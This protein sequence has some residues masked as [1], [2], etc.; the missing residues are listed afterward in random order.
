MDQFSLTNN[1]IGYRI[2]VAK[3]SIISNNIFL[4]GDPVGGGFRMLYS[5]DNCVVRNNI[6]YKILWDFPGLVSNQLQNNLFANQPDMT[7]NFPSANF[8]NVNT[9]NLFVSYDNSGF[10]YNH[11]FHLSVPASFVG[12]DATQ[13]GLY[14]TLK[15]WKAGSVPMTPHIESKNIA[16]NTDAA[17]KIQVQV[18]VSAQNN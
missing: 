10:T 9:E 4:G 5:L 7:G 17:G 1:I 12:T 2:Y 14:G 18:K 11:Y 6:F 8:Y 15:P 16:E 3:N 13:V